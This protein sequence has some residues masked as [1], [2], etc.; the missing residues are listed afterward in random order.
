MILTAPTCINVVVSREAQRVNKRNKRIVGYTTK[1]NR[2]A[3]Q[4]RRLETTIE[5]KRMK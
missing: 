4:N 2:V 1:E 3:R 5:E